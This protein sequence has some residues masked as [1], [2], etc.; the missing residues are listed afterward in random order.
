MTPALEVL[1]LSKRFGGL[2]ATRECLASVVPGERRLIIGRNGAARHH[3]VQPDHRRSHGLTQFGKAVRAGAA[4]NPDTAARASGLARTYQIRH[5]SERRRSAQ[6]GAGAARSRSVAL[7]RLDVPPPGSE[8]SPMTRRAALPSAS[9]HG[10]RIAP[11]RRF[12]WRAAAPQMAMALA[13]KPKV[14]LLDEPLAGCPGRA[15]PDARICCRAC[16]A[17]SPS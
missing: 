17:T 12:L 3:A 14:L 9:A 5:C 2:P 13:Q 7:E 16:R 1:S 6:R 10:A 11:S 15:R 8:P 4:A